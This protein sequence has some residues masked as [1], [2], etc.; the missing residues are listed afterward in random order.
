MAL[1]ELGKMIPKISV[2][3]V[4]FNGKKFLKTCLSSILNNDYP[5]FEVLLVDNN[6]QDGSVSLVKKFFPRVKIIESRKN[7]GFAGGNNLG[8]KKA[9]GEYLL[10]INNDTRV[11][12]TYL[13]DLLQAF[14]DIPHLACVQPKIVTMDN[15]DEIDACGSFLTGSL[16]L[17]HYGYRKSSLSEQ[18]QKPF[19]VFSVKGAAMMIK[20]SVAEKIGLFDEDFWCYYEESDF[21]HRCWLF[22][23]ECWYYPKAL[24]YHAAGGTSLKYFENDFIQYQNFKNKLASFIKN[25][26]SV[27]LIKRLPLY[28]SINILLSFFWL[29]GGK[30]KHFI[31]LYKAIWWNIMNLPSTLKK[32]K[33]IQRLRKKSDR[34]IGMKVKKNP[35]LSYYYYI[36]KGL[37]NY[38]DE[39][40]TV[41]V[42]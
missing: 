30:P 3:V 31:S 6:S 15:P 1:W 34:E 29:A 17:Y 25:F 39:E 11:G 19:P 26:E 32:R 24:T 23:W 8:F 38:P 20:R 18:Y 10:L 35:R 37:E 5:N 16:F 4:N 41:L 40:I 13:R 28:L 27:S 9:A 21:C 36:F 12:K 42:Q 2:I 33:K 14:K 7:L 22:G